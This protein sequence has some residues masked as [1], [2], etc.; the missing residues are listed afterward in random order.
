M[1]AT[2]TALQPTVLTLPWRAAAGQPDA[3]RGGRGN[4]PPYGSTFWDQWVKYFVT[5][6]PNANPLTLDPL[7]PGPWQ[8]RII[9]LSAIQDANKT[10]FSAL[11]AKGG[12][13]LIA[14]AP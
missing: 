1:N 11:R 8:Q 5:R 13:I 7:N 3:A 6:D 14:Q 12:K 4:T 9:D 10:D 2:Q